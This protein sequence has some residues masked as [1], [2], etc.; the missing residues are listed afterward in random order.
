MAKK[1]TLYII[2][3]QGAATRQLHLSRW[4]LAAF[5]VLACGVLAGLGL[6]LQDY[7]GLK[8]GQSDR[9]WMQTRLI[10]QQE[11]IL[12]QRG[13][14]QAFAVRMNGLKDTLADLQDFEH[15][16]RVMA[17]LEDAG[18]EDVEGGQGLLGMGGSM[19][20]DLDPSLSLEAP[21]AGM[22]R[23]M[24]DQAMELAAL[25]T[26]Q[27]QGFESLYQ[28]LEEQRDL[29]A[30]TPSTRPL[31]EGWVSSRFGMRISPF[32]GEKEFHKGLDLAAPFGTPVICPANGRVIFVGR[33]GGFGRMIA[34]DHGHGTITRYA[35][36]S[37]IRKKKGDWI[38]RGESI[39]EVGNTGRTTGSHLHYEVLVN[40]IPTNPER[41]ILN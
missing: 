7:Q 18:P 8:G 28:H 17:N 40:G 11:E 19:P 13:Q 24:N 16:I 12:D 26:R 10:L 4:H 22:V 2:P 5:L 20:D 41:Y 9:D 32:T 15:K 3:E 36:L 34:I 35:H 31:T 14:I 38:R 23:E 1:Y 25:S 33:K 6:F 39:A 21:H 27:E 37:R 30:C 29:L